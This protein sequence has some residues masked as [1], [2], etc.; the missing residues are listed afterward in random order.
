MPAIS[1]AREKGKKFSDEFGRFILHFR[2]AKKFTFLSTQRYCCVV[3][4]E[5]VD[6]KRRLEGVPSRHP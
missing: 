5:L 3:I 2:K 4:S 6:L 1:S